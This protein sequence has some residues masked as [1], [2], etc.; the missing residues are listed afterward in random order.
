M[1]SSYDIF[2][3]PLVGLDLAKHI[4]LQTDYAMSFL[5]SNIEDFSDALVERLAVLQA[6][7][8]GF[9]WF[10]KRNDLISYDDAG[11]VVVIYN[12]DDQRMQSDLD[13]L[14]NDLFQLLE[15]KRDS[16]ILT[17]RHMTQK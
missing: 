11:D 9:L 14:M 5:F 15:G 7:L 6:S 4:Y 17:L 12:E 10:R 16:K 8:D 2:Q 3:I 13:T 1:A